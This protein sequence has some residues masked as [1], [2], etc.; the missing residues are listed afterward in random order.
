MAT[1]T[2]TQDTLIADIIVN[3]LNPCVISGT[4][5][6]QDGAAVALA[7]VS[8]LVCTLYDKAS[9]TIL[10]SRDAQ[11]ILN[12]NGGTLDATSGAFTLTLDSDDNVIVSTTLPP[13]NTET[14]L[15]LIV[16]EWS[17]GGYWSGLVRVRVRQVHRAP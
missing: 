15:A 2:A 11:S 3:E 8:S 10:N 17:G 4:L 5:E 12:T 14:H 13:G 7:S 1:V 9:D 16:A 6:D